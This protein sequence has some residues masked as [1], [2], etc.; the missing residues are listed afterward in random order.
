VLGA[1]EVHGEGIGLIDS[2]GSGAVDP[3][4]ALVGHGV[5][6]REIAAAEQSPS[7]LLPHSTAGCVNV[8]TLAS[9]PYSTQAASIAYR[10][11]PSPRSSTRSISTR[12]FGTSAAARLASVASNSASSRSPSDEPPRYASPSRSVSGISVSARSVGRISDTSLSGGP[13]RYSWS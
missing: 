10:S 11:S 8:E 6:L 4:F 3:Q 2:P 7:R 13:A 9:S 12:R 1:P 5:G